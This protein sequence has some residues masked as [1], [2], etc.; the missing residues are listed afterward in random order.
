M[1]LCVCLSVL[2]SPSVCL[3]DIELGLCIWER[4]PYSVYRMVSLY[5]DLL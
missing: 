2:F 1:V 5:I 4:A 3:D